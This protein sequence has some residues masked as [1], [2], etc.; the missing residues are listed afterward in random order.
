MLMWVFAENEVSQV[1]HSTARGTSF[2]DSFS[3]LLGDSSIFLPVNSIEVH[4]LVQEDSPETPAGVT[5][6]GGE[7]IQHFHSASFW[8]T[9][10]R[11]MTMTIAIT[12][13]QTYVKPMN[14]YCMYIY[15]IIYIYII[16]ITKLT[17]VSN[18]YT[19]LIE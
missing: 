2:S 11:T 4:L 8:V 12:H 13:I 18:D 5:G 16:Y 3:Q 19:P 7:Q 10:S 15:I 1:S 9:S 14:I 17:G 6:A